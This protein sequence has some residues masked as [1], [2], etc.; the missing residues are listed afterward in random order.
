MRNQPSLKRF[1]S[2]RQIYR[3]VKRRIRRAIASR[4]RGSRAALE[5]LLVRLLRGRTRRQLLSM[6]RKPALAG[7]LACAALATPHA[8]ADVIELADIAADTDPRGFAMYGITH[9]FF[10]GISVSAA[11]DVN[12]DGLDDVIVGT[13]RSHTD[14]GAAYVVFG[15]E[16]GEAVELADVQQ[17]TG[18][19]M[20]Q[21][22]S[23]Y[24]QAGVVVSDAGDVNGD[25]L[26]DLLV[27]A[28]YT[29]DDFAP[30]GSAYVV[31]G[32]ADES[33]VQLSDVEAGIGGFAMHGDM[34][35]AVWT[36]SA[37]GDMNGDGL[38]DVLI[39][40]SE[41]STNGYLAGAAFVVFGKTNGTEVQLSEIADGT[42]TGGFAIFGAAAWDRAAFSVSGAGDVN[43]DGTPDVIIGAPQLSSIGVE[44]RPGRAYV[45]FGKSSATPIDLA[46]IEMNGGDKGFAIVGEAINETAGR[47]VAGGG[48]VNGD[49]LDDVIVS[50]A[51][52]NE[53]RTFTGKTYVVFGKSTG[54]TVQLADVASDN[55]PSG[56]L[57]TEQTRGLHNVAELSDI[58]GDGLA[59]IL[60]GVS[61]AA[62]N[63]LVYV[64]FGKSDG[65]TVSLADL[66][67]LG[68]TAGFAI[69]GVASGD[70]AGFSVSDAGDANGD[71]LMDIMI[72]APGADVNGNTAGAA[73]VLFAPFFADVVWVDF[74]HAGAEDGSIESP[75][76]TLAEA[77]AHVP[78]HGI[79]KIK[80]DTAT[81]TSPETP[82]LTKPMTIEANGGAV[83][84]GAP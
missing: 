28:P 51:V 70:A 48:D 41:E 78:D 22:A 33:A 24:D 56:F 20:I 2:R 4:W 10:A 36:C 7:L 45:V 69:R 58:N 64:A 3:Y 55:D 49:G 18:G 17:G 44:D 46:D 37:I 79:I 11:G 38:D 65:A 5:R 43:N 19:F 62:E 63:G 30:A 21:G 6:A 13:K 40:A 81:N 8:R 76:N 12:G 66:E 61:S 34:Y 42:N 16:N 74:A 27:V 47:R 26:S 73:Y 80:A 54:T 50:S 68:S 82:T 15:K 32:K 9:F 35:D 60:I 77:V 67:S 23:Q 29:I 71:G 72:G 53:D 59:E 39:G 14:F 1:T 31:F 25:G 57:I 75:Y 84:I 52:Y 83:T